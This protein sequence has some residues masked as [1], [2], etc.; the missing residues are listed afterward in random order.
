VTTLGKT[1]ELTDLLFAHGMDPNRP[2]WL[3][4]TPLHRI[5]ERGDI[6]K[7]T[8]FIEHG[9]NLDTLDDE[10]CSTPLGYAAKYGQTQ[11]VEFLLRRGANPDLPHDPA[12]ARPLAWATRREHDDIVRLLASR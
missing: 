7:A 8:I 9:A 12:W 3:G 6:E 2:N 5:A 10:F 4:I 1:R 11:M